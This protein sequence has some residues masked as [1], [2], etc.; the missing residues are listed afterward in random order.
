MTP[1]PRSPD[2]VDEDRCSPAVP[3]A[4]MARPTM[5]ESNGYLK[6]AGTSFY[7]PAIKEIARQVWSAAPPCDLF[8]AQLAIAPTGQYAGSVRVYAAGR[9]IGSIPASMLEQFRP[10]VAELTAAGQPATCRAIVDP[11]STITG[12]GLLAP[13]KPKVATAS[14][15]FLPQLCGLTVD[16]PTETAERLDAALPSRAKNY[17]RRCSGELDCASLTLV[18]DGEHLGP[19][20]VDDT[21]ALAV[22]RHVAGLG[23]PLTCGVRVIRAPERKLR[24][25]ADLPVPSI[26]SSDRAG[27]SFDLI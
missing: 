1:A 24:V 14:E 4:W 21:E 19:V 26:G 18:L 23:M 17:I 7:Q 2:Q 25:V 11:G 3:V 6:L 15:P 12:I 8:M 27:L 22:V 13:S 10:I 5:L 9:R 20:A 16:V